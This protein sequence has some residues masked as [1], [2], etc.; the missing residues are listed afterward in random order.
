MLIEN[1]SLKSLNT[2]GVD[3]YARWLLRIQD[4]TR[5][6]E[7]LSDIRHRDFPILTLGYGSNVLFTKNF[8]GLIVHIESQR[9][10]S[11][12]ETSSERTVRVEAG[13]HWHD[14]VLWSIANGYAGLENLSLIPGSVGACPIQ[15]IGAYGVEVASYISKIEVFDRHTFQWDELSREQCQF[16]YRSSIFKKQPDRYI[17]TA[18]HFRFANNPLLTLDYPGIREALFAAGIENPNA[19]NVSDIICSIREQKLPNPKIQGNA[20]SFF[21]NPV[22]TARNGEELREKHPH[23]PLHVVGQD[24]VKVSAAWLIEYLGFKGWREGDAGISKQHA[25]V[26]VNYGKATGAQLLTLANR[27]QEAVASK[28]NIVLEPEPRII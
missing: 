24:K 19:R 20:G 13:H 3:V 27:I 2:F 28:F 17:I 22:I 11:T 14:F 1:A 21:K 18:V 4:C 25:L 23:I 26:L 6:P 7:L 10:N 9:I 5:L 12:S 8:E 15:N 16:E